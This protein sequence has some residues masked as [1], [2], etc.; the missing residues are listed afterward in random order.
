MKKTLKAAAAVAALA[1]PATAANL[2]NPLYMPKSG[3]VYSKTSAGMMYKK[4]NDNLAMQAKEHAGAIEFPIWRISEDIG[5]GLADWLTLRGSFGYTHDND[6]DRSGM[7]NGRLGL[8]FR[9]FDGTEFVDGWVWDIYFDAHLGGV[10]KMKAELVMSPNMAMVADG[11]YPLSFNYDNYSNGRWGAWLGTQVGK[12]F[13][14]LTVAAFGEVLH[15]FGSNYNEIRIGN[16]VDTIVSGMLLAEGYGAL[17]PSY[18]A[19]LPKTFSVFTDSTW[20]YSA[21]LKALYEIDDDWSVGGS[22]TYKHRA[23][24]TIEGVSLKNSSTTPSAGVVAGITAG[25]ADSFIGPMQDAIDEYILA[26]VIARQLTETVQ[27][28]VYGEYTFDD[29]Q[30]KSQNG[31]DVKWELGARL[32]LRF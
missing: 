13:D 23:E 25:I 16:G 9:V 5:V 29:A 30:A 6:I 32:N 26:A 11:S 31:T 8:N 4:A 14:N 22:F 3:E 7:H 28:A 24:N 27:V 1:S 18:V 21:G 20:E 17:I 2:E 10:S 12:T 15:T 19:G